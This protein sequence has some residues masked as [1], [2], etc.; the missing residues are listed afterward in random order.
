M[1]RPKV[2][3]PHPDS[4]TKPTDSPRAIAKLTPSTARTDSAGC[5]RTIE[6]DERR[7]G[8]CI[9]SPLTSRTGVVDT[10][11]NSRRELPLHRKRVLTWLAMRDT[12]LSLA[13]PL[14]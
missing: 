11:L 12:E 5:R 7:S 4:P 6:R 2:D 14:F 10:K 13:D 3:F 8:K 9:S 1:H